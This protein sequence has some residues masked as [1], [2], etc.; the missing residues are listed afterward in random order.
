METPVTDL[1][2]RAKVMEAKESVV[3]A[4]N[5][6]GMTAHHSMNRSDDGA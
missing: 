3:V 5:S 2:G 1:A 4:V 6:P